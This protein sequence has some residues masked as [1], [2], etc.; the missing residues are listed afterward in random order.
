MEIE[1]IIGRT[2]TDI[3]CIYGIEDDWLDTAEVFIE[4]DKAFYIDIPFGHVARVFDKDL[5]PA[6]KSIFGD[7]SDIPCYS[8]NQEGK[9]INE[10]SN[11]YQKRRKNIFN[12]LRKA[13]FGYQLTIK[14]YQPYK[15]EYRENKLKYIINRKIVDFLWEN[16]C[17]DKGFLEL[18]NGYL[19]SEQSM[20]PSG[21]GLAGLHYYDSLESLKERKGENLSRLSDKTDRHFDLP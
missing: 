10:I 15:V 18:D 20:A 21:T 1:E 12:R 2:I 6:A 17:R 11:N 9:S 8:V 13:L 4:L 5:D 16:D 3:Y 14:E 19:I 7:L